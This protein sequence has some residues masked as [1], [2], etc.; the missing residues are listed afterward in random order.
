MNQV[1]PVDIYSVLADWQTP[2][3]ALPLLA[4]GNNTVLNHTQKQ[5]RRLLSTT[6]W[7]FII[8]LSYD[9]STQENVFSFPNFL[10]THPGW[11]RYQKK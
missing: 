3:K 6:N 2:L 5:I 11:Q 10:S 8:Y 7:I 1:L 4:G 9:I